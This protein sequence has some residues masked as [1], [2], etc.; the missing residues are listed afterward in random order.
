MVRRPR[1]VLIQPSLSVRLH[2]RPRLALRCGFDAEIAWPG[3]LLR[4]LART[5]HVGWLGRRG[6]AQ[7]SP[8]A[9][10][11]PR[12]PRTPCVTRDVGCLIFA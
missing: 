8:S 12:N 4:G 2:G 3:V 11:L 7:T 6:L 5:R 10:K 9:D 1:L